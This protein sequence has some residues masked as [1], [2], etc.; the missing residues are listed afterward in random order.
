[1]VIGQETQGIN[2]GL[3]LLKKKFGIKEKDCNFD[4]LLRKQK[5]I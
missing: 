1:M 4:T 5:T 2:L 3:R